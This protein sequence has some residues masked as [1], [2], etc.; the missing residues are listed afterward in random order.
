[1]E[2]TEEVI[3][4]SPSNPKHC[5]ISLKTLKIVRKNGALPFTE[6][7]LNLQ[8]QFL[9]PLYFADPKLCIG[10]NEIPAFSCLIFT[11]ELLEVV[12]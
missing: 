4:K 12:K 2:E 3:G 1:M 7:V 8:I 11:V 5:S 10:Q 9:V 6:F